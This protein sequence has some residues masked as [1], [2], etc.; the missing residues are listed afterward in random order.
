MTKYFKKSCKHNKGSHG[1]TDSNY[2]STNQYNTIHADKHKCKPCN[3][4]NQ[5]NKV[6]GQ[7]STPKTT[8]PEPK[9]KDPHGSDSP[10]SCID[11]SSDSEWL[12]WA[13]KIIE[14]KLSNMK[15]AANFPITINNNNTISLFDT[16][17]TV[18]SMS[19]ACFDKL[20]PKPA[21]V[22]THTYKVNGT[23]G[24]SIGLLRTTTCTLKFTKKIP[25]AVH[26]LQTPLPKYFRLR[27]LT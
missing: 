23:N 3:T 12:S 14:V 22:Q 8:K 1:S 18:S 15:Y 25:T 5:V 20:K 7:T 6:I 17:G 24:N 11:S 9:D 4:N 27:F 13:D 26:S 16:G 19:K 10:D 2:P 21:L